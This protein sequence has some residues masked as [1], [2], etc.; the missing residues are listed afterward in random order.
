M[1]MAAPS[2]TSLELSNYPVHSTPKRV[3]CVCVK[4]SLEVTN[5]QPKKFIIIHALENIISTVR[6]KIL[7][8]TD[9]LSLLAFIFIKQYFEKNLEV[10]VFLIY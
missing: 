4:V 6:R 2:V 7:K 10:R 3:Y 8:S 1:L 9:L 5:N